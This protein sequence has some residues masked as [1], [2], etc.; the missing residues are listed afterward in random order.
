MLKQKDRFENNSIEK[1]MFNT[2]EESMDELKV[3]CNNSSRAQITSS[4]ENENI[5]KRPEMK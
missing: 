3:A 5:S 2:M 4:E 1:G